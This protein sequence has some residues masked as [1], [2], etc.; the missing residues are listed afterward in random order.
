MPTNQINLEIKTLFT[1][2]SDTEI[3]TEILDSDNLLG[4]LTY[5]QALTGFA[6][7]NADN[8][9]ICTLKKKQ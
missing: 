8:D 9:Q 7:Q 4:V 5:G 3:Y 6:S 1:D 2:T